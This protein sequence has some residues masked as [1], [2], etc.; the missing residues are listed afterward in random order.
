MSP[1]VMWATQESPLRRSCMFLH[2]IV[3]LNCVSVLH[4]QVIDLFGRCCDE[5]QFDA[6]ALPIP[7]PVLTQGR[8]SV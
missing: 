5:F 3:G 4:W 6:I 8:I 2:N 1:M 7:Q